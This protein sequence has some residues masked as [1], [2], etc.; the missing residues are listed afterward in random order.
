MCQRE[1]ERLERE[2]LPSPLV[3][4]LSS[5]F[6]PPLNWVPHCLPVW[7]LTPG[8]QLTSLA[9]SFSL[10]P[11]VQQLHV[12]NNRVRISGS[13]QANYFSRNSY[14]ANALSC[15]IK[16]LDSRYGNVWCST[17]VKCLFHQNYAILQL[18]KGSFVQWKIS[19]Y[20]VHV[21]LFNSLSKTSFAMS[22]G[23]A[24][25]QGIVH[26]VMV[27][28][29]YLWCGHTHCIVLNQ[30]RG[31]SPRSRLRLSIDLQRKS[32]LREILNQFG[33]KFKLKGLQWEPG[34]TKL[35]TL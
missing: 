22:R 15:V 4:Q 9:V 25:Y 31:S 18:Y 34:T 33:L 27:V 23:F 20:M 14:P 29:V 6:L 17:L 10:L 16:Q 2:K 26:S 19:A 32:I 1:R 11:P 30:Q 35:S 13:M 24:F 28:C 21:L 5:V 12:W 3:W 8:M 7:T